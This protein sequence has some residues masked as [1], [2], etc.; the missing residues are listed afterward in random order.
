MQGNLTNGLKNLA[1][2]QK[3]K[4]VRMYKYSEAFNNQIELF[5]KSIPFSDELDRD[6]RWIKLAYQIDWKNFEI[7]YA[8]AFSHT[9]RPALKA[10][11]V[12]GALIIKHKYQLSDEEVALQIQENPYLQFFIG[13]QKYQKH[14]PFHSSTLTN[15]RK[16]LGEKQFDEFERYVINDL[17]AKKLIKPKGL[18]LD[19]TVYES[20]ITFPT[21]CGLLN[22]ARQ[23]C[24]EQIKKFSKIVGIKVRTYCRSAQKA[25]ISFTRK[26]RKSA[27]EIRQMQKRMLQYLRRNIQQLAELIEIISEK[28]IEITDKVLTKVETAKKIYEQQK[29]MYDNRVKSIESR[30]VSFHKAYIRPIVR[31]KSGKTT[32]FG[33]KVAA[34][35]VDGYMFLDHFSFENFNESTTLRDSVE[36]YK[37]RFGKYPSYVSMDQIYATRENRE[38]LKERGIRC[39]AKPLGRPKNDMSTVNEQRWRHQKHKER[40]RIEGGFGHTKTKYLMGEVRAKT[41]ETEYSWIRMGLLAHNL[42][43]AA[44]RA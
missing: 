29:Y 35:Y 42:V 17:T 38:Y 16:R 23:F 31:N 8:K 37:N 10:R 22:K 25:Y 20:D 34:S 30:I 14:P 33:P 11:M 15:V 18:L 28:G 6:N 2:L 4:V 41:P 32:E 36:K 9:G 26:R 13:L 27:Q 24:V 43:T 21:D 12:I 39:A 7:E 40:N 19:A 44:H 1:L 5:E 3:R